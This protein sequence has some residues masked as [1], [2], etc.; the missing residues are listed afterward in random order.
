MRRMLLGVLVLAPVVA[1]AVAMQQTVSV[2]TT[3]Q[4]PFAPLSSGDA[5]VALVGASQTSA[6]VTVSAASVATANDILDITSSDDSWQVHA[7]YLSHSG[8]SDPLLT[9]TFTLSLREGATSVDQ[10][11]VV[12]GVATVTSGGPVDLV[13]THDTELFAQSSLL[14]LSG[15]LQIQLILTPDAGSGPTLR[16]DVSI[17]VAA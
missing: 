15:S 9:P 16:Y 1:G 14:S 17:T 12:D 8:F 13:T 3:S 5:G 10:V 6:S 7:E 4:A 2:D 11:R